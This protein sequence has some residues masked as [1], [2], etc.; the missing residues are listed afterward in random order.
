MMRSSC[1]CRPQAP[2]KRRAE[3]EGQ[4]FADLLQLDQ[5]EEEVL[6]PAGPAPQHVG[7]SC[8]LTV[9]GI[10]QQARWLSCMLPAVQAAFYEIIPLLHLMQG[11]N[12][13]QQS[14]GP[15][16]ANGLGGHRA[17]SVCIPGTAMSICAN[18]CTYVG[19]CAATC[20]SRQGHLA[21][22]LQPACARA[23]GT[24]CG[25]CTVQICCAPPAG[26]SI[27]FVCKVGASMMILSQ[28]SCMV[29]SD[30]A[31]LAHAGLPWL[32]RLSFHRCSVFCSSVADP[33]A[34]TGSMQF[35]VRG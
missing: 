13:T 3:P 31:Q 15:A 28:R 6:T 29:H 17:R 32:R 11:N 4:Q 16:S 20:P 10:C 21:A 8:S 23:P 25:E 12:G 9:A 19:R 5:L 18:D 34:A 7:T 1:L 14:L 26:R 35:Q 27:P 33:R 22:S 30:G 24:G 2:S